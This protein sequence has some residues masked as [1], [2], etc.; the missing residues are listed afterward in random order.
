MGKS[1]TY[2]PKPFKKMPKGTKQLTVAGAIYVANADRNGRKIPE[3]EFRRRIKEAEDF[4]LR[5]FGGFTTDELEH[6]EF[7][8][9]MKKKVICERVARVLNF[10]DSKTFK[11]HRASLERW[12]LKKK[13]EWNQEAIAYEF[14]GDMYYI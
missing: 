5:L 1:Y 7:R 10:S 9:A 12:L 13:S 6:G 4:M 14:E 11:K 2:A 3:K 8:S